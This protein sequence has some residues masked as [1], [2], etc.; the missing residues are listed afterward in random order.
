M[1]KFN[2]LAFVL[3]LLPADGCGPS[4]EDINRTKRLNELHQQQADSATLDYLEKN[5][6]PQEA[7]EASDPIETQQ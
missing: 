7:Q 2:T 3:L 5:P 1:C 6:E 4:Q